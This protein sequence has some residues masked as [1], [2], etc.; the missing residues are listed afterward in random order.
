MK[1]EEKTRSRRNTREARQETSKKLEEK[2]TRS[3]TRNTADAG[4]DTSQMQV[5]GGKADAG[6]KTSEKQG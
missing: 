3:R 1:Q 4:H 6:G 2:Q 5:G